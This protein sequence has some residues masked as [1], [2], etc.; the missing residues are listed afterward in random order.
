MPFDRFD[1]RHFAW[2]G[3]DKTVYDDTPDCQVC[4][5]ATKTALKEKTDGDWIRICKECYI[6]MKDEGIFDAT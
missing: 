4:A 6:D 2:I 1:D 5:S 3:Q